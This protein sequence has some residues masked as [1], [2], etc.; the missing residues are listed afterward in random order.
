MVEQKIISAANTHDANEYIGKLNKDG[1]KVVQ[2][3]ASKNQY[4]NTL[5][6]LFEKD[7]NDKLIND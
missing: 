7:S 1:W 2:I 5:W 6:M 3:A 4:S